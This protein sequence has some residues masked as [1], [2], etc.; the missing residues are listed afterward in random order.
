MPYK[1]S[2]LE[3]DCVYHIYGRS[4]GQ[5]PLFNSEENYCHFLKLYNKHV[6]CVT[7][8]YCYCLMPNHFHFLI[9]IKEAK[10]LQRQ[11]IGSKNL[12]NALSKK[13]SNLFNAYSKAYNKQYK[14][15]GSLFERPF[16]RKKVED[17]KYLLNLVHYIH[18]NP[19]EA[20]L[21]LRPEQ[22]RYSSYNA[23]LK[24]ALTLLKA[25]EVISWF[26][27]E[28]NFIDCHKQPPIH[29]GVEGN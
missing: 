1:L 17:E 4:N 29:S 6:G 13:F 3:P 23:L 25:R 19:V 7:D 16:K 2:A 15:H 14:R 9:R 8:T 28:E 18:F 10:D 21:V 22:Y 12:P 20:G 24:P 27:N 26:G 5:A 11:S